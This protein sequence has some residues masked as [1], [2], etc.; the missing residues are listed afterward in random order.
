MAQKEAWDS[1]TISKTLFGIFG[2][3]PI[4]YSTI[5][6]ISSEAHYRGVSFRFLF[7]VVVNHFSVHFLSIEVRTDMIEVRGRLSE[8]RSRLLGVI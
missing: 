2:L 4:T 1:G 3:L 8:K 7:G 6:G 5:M